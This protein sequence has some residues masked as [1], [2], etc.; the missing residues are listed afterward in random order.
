MNDQTVMEAK[1]P[2]EVVREQLKS[3]I[4]TH[5]TKIQQGKKLVK[6]GKEMMEQVLEADQEYQILDA[7]QKKFTRDRKNRKEI[8]VNK[9]LSVLK[10]YDDA[11]KETRELEEALSD[12]LNEYTR[13]T[14]ENEITTDTGAVIEI[15]KTAKVLKL[16]QL[17][18]L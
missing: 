13:I 5:I 8:V 11:R 2:D 1:A 14:G 4:V 12:Y 6:A 16:E 18:L 17:Q 15:V 3:L 9:N 10:Q 7:E